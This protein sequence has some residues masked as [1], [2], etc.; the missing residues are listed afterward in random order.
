MKSILQIL[1]LVFAALANVTAQNKAN[2]L[3]VQSGL[4]Y[5]LSYSDKSIGA[6]H[7][8]KQSSSFGLQFEKLVSETW[9]LSFELNRTKSKSEITNYSEFLFSSIANDIISTSEG[10][11][12]IDKEYSQVALLVK[13]YFGERNK[14]F[15]ELG[16]DIK[17]VR[18]SSGSWNYIL[19]TFYN[20]SIFTNPIRLD[21]PEVRDIN[22]QYIR[23]GGYLGANIG[24]GYQ[25]NI[26]KNF[27]L[28]LKGRISS[29]IKQTEERGGIVY[30]NIEI[31]LGVKY[32]IGRAKKGDL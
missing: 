6:K 26:I 29:Q 2:F 16:W 9:S 22:S 25:L 5:D 30:R 27:N 14:I 28:I 23:R 1:I 11:I 13:K 17:T 10:D 12:I 8:H 19:T 15:I 21:E 3:G 31:L 18:E 7:S 4:N 20:N 32:R 24:I